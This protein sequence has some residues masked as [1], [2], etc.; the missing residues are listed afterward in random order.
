VLRPTGP[1]SERKSANNIGIKVFAANPLFHV[2]LGTASISPDVTTRQATL[3][4]QFSANY[5][6]SVTEHEYQIRSVKLILT[7]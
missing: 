4:Q 6:P 7:A 5:Q 3:G 1:V 2:K